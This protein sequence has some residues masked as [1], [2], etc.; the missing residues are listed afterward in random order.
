M[1]GALICTVALGYLPGASPSTVAANDPNNVRWVGRTVQQ[2]D[3]VY[4]DWEG[5]SATVNVENFTYLLARIVDNCPGSGAGGGS[6]WGVTMTSSDTYAAAADHRVATFF[7]GSIIQNYY[8]FNLP[9]GGHSCNPDCNINGTTTFTL[10]RLTESRISGCSQTQ[11]LSVA[12]FISDGMFVA[13]ASDPHHMG[14][15]NPLLPNGGN[16]PVAHATRRMEFIGDSISAGDLNDG[17]QL[18]PGGAQP[19]AAGTVQ[20]VV[21]HTH[22]HTA[23]SPATTSGGTFATFSYLVQPRHSNVNQ[24]CIY[25]HGACRSTQ[26]D[27]RQLGFQRRYYLLEWCSALHIS[28]RVWCRLYVHCMG[29]DPARGT[30][31]YPHRHLFR[32]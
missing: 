3:S 6:R 26:H 22:T 25:I 15:P 31:R 24:I 1:I 20:S 7:S 18:G 2:A 30:S 19:T 27:L 23:S 32:A 16:G 11:N 4:F 13:H 14:K 8:L 28:L 10:T 17:G 21:A 29:R 12:A 9:G 5:V